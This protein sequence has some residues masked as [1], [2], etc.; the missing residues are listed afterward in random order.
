MPD[1]KADRTVQML[2]DIPYK[3]KL[4]QWKNLTNLVNDHVFTIFSLSKFVI[5]IM[6]YSALLLD[7]L[8]L[9]VCL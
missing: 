2:K 6:Y 4:Q 1:W 5:T 3:G 7:M 9:S 8:I